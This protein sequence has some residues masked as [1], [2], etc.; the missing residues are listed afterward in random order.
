[1]TANLTVLARRWPWGIVLAAAAACTLQSSYFAWKVDDAFIT[2][3]YAQNWVAGH[4]VVFNVGERVEGYTCFLWVALSA[5]GLLAGAD[6]LRW[7]LTLSII[8]AVATVGAAWQLAREL[9]PARSCNAAGLTALLVGLYP[10]LAW[11]AGSGME[12]TLFTC[13]VTLALFLHIRAGA[14]SVAAPVCLALASMTRPEAWLLAGLACVDAVSI[15]PGRRAGRYAGIFLGIFGPYYFW[16]LLYYDALLPNTFYAKV[17]S[18]GT[19]VMRGLSY[20]WSFVVDG[21]G[22]YFF[23]GAGFS[24]APSV[25]RRARL[26]Y[27]FLVA[28]TVYVVSIGGDFLP[29]FRFFLPIVPTLAALFTAALVGWTERLLRTRKAALA[30]V[31][32]AAVAGVLCTYGPLVASQ[33]DSL[34]LFNNIW[35]MQ[36]STCRQINEETGADDAVAAVGVGILK[37]CTGRRVIDMAG[38]TDVH[39][40]HQQSPRMGSG[41]PGHEKYD[42]EYV[43]AQR[44]KFIVIPRPGTYEGIPLAPLADMWG[45]P[46]LQEHY[47]PDPIGYRRI[48]PWEG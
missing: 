36:V 14:E 5:L 20:L 25:A 43:L 15:G 37:F 40:A 32:G 42:S 22:W 1:M 17:G 9:L 13:L 31:R 26:A 7:S 8:G 12:T 19:Q 39:I 4:G 29:G 28:Y 18:S 38:L 48:D 11:W 16:R 33:E 44:P 46:L 27:V 24:L 23:L 3:S 45:Q 35:K 21:G 34:R 10:P 47:V 6:I 30:V 2:F 41:L